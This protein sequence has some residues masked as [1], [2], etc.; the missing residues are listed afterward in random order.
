MGDEA[1]NEIVLIKFLLVNDGLFAKY[2]SFVR[3]RPGQ[4][5]AKDKE[6]CAGYR[7]DCDKEEKF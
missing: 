7:C 3:P 6:K 1:Q 4:V 5:F 2:A